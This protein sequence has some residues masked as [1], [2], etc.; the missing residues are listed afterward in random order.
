V[1]C[2]LGRETGPGLDPGCG[3][4][5]G[6]LQPLARNVD[7]LN[8]VYLDEDGNVTATP[9]DIRTIEVTIVA[10]SGDDEGGLLFSHTDNTA[11]QNQRGQV[12]LPAQ[13]D[14]FRRF[15]LTATVHCRNL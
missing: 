3:G 8:F 2:H 4:A 11:Y 10:R 6:G 12:I 15:R 1:E 7:A 14:G 13:N 5:T 9:G